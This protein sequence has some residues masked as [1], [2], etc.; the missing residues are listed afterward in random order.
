MFDVL[1]SLIPVFSLIALGAVL[2]RFKLLTPEGWS[3]LERLTYFVL[4]PPLM[5]MSIVEGRFAGGEALWLGLTLAATVAT[6]GALMLTMRPL[7]AKDGA[8]FSSVFQAGIRWNG[9]VTLGVL[10]GLY[11]DEGV[12]LSAVGFAT[13]VP[14]N[15]VMSVLVLSRYAGSEPAPFK[16]V[17]RSIIT[18]PLIISTVVAI[19]LV[20][21]GVRVSKPVGETLN[22][23]GDA[24]V[25]LGLICVGAALDISSMKEARW[26]LIAGTLLRLI[27][28]PAVTVG[29]AYAIGLS[30]M[31]FQVAVVCASAPVAT[32]AYIL[33]RQL[34][35]DSKL[36]A[37]I[38]TLSTLLSL[39]TIPAT[40]LLA[41]MLH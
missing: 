18:N 17:V 37:N 5:F 20:S 24:T 3:A 34:G 26:P 32:S 21:A 29:L 28:M 22:L 25:A 31:V 30:S 36:M 16:R 11:G 41:Q 27:V 40:I 4:F 1:L 15:N 23:L 13:L 7:L 14:M 33:S 35:G 2:R 12:A 38:I 10:A 9:Y 8:Q 39:F 6:M 19:I